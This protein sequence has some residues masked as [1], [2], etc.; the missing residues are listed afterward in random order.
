MADADVVH[1]FCLNQNEVHRDAIMVLITG[2]ILIFGLFGVSSSFM[3]VGY[4]Y[5]LFLEAKTWVN[6]KL[7]CEQDGGQLA[8]ITDRHLQVAIQD[9]LNEEL[10]GTAVKS[11]WMGLSDRAEEGTYI[12]E[13]G[14]EL[15]EGDFIFWAPHEPNNNDKKND[16]GQDCGGLWRRYNW[17]WDD[18]YCHKVRPYLCQF[19]IC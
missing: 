6:A 1:P 5:V 18:G 11:V 4:D 10:V 9:H 3:C 12:W 19:S 14:S 15:L 17:R 13:E 7:A 16:N 2:L 8:S